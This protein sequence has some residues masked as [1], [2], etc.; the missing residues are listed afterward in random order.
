M[1]AKVEKPDAKNKNKFLDHR[2]LNHPAAIT[3]AD[4]SA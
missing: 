3:H 2:F 1:T 4:S